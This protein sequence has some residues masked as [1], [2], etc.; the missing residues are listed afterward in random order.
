MGVGELPSR[1]D[2]GIVRLRQRVIYLQLLSR[3]AG[4]KR[5]RRHMCR[6]NWPGVSR[7]QQS[8][9][10]FSIHIH[11]DEVFLAGGKMKPA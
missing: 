6:C 1:V 9:D 2:E 11:W 4:D 5:R 7:W 3:Q 10:H 8:S